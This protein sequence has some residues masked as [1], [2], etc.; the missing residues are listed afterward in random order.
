VPL[1]T[2]APLTTNR[3]SGSWNPNNPESVT[4]L[5]TQKAEI[6]Q[7]EAAA[8]AEREAAKK[9]AFAAA[10]AKVRP[11]EILSHCFETTK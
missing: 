2:R 9:A 11:P 7:R 10:A 3:L 1:P 4:R 8:K 6:K 5:A